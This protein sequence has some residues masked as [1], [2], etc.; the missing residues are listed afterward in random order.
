MAAVTYSPPQ[1]VATTI[2]V[3]VGEDVYTLE[4]GV[5]CEVPEEQRAAVEAACIAAVSGATAV[6]TDPDE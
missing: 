4:A 5:P 3:T 6:T 1:G 2:V